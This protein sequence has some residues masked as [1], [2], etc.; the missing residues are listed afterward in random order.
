MHRSGVPNAGPVHHHE[1]RSHNPTVMY[2]LC[3]VIDQIDHAQQSLLLT[4]DGGHGRRAG[5]FRGK[6]LRVTADEARLAV[7]DGQPGLPVGGLVEGDRVCV[8]CRL[9]RQ[10]A[11]IPD[12][13]SACAIEE[14]QASPRR[15]ER[16]GSL[17]A[18]GVSHRKLKRKLRGV[19]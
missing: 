11:V 3:G 16:S 18:A 12:T 19:A 8:R 7:P 15:F 6:Q 5:R 14:L 2:R 17:L 9:P 10:L 13:V 4:V 1:R